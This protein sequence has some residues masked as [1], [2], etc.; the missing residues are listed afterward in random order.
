MK[1]MITSALGPKLAGFAIIV[2]L[3]L[4]VASAGGMVSQ[5]Y[6]Q[7]HAQD[8]RCAGSVAF[9]DQWPTVLRSQ[10][11]SDGQVV[12]TWYG[13][14]VVP[15]L[16]SGESGESVTV[17]NEAAE[18]RVGDPAAAPYNARD[19]TY[20]EGRNVWIYEPAGEPPDRPPE[21]LPQGVEQ[22][23]QWTY[24][25]NREYWYYE[26]PVADAGVGG[27]VAPATETAG[28]TW[29]TKE[30]YDEAALGDAHQSHTLRY[31]IFRKGR[32]RFRV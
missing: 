17:P 23:G 29:R 4:V 15:D 2:T 6:R 24:H 9:T 30:D 1:K 14:G 12:L 11:G 16:N 26:P 10:M 25:A 27:A 31:V 7:A 8:D 20:V 5:D 13:P 32:G 22:G 3:A 19:W 28:C 21:T 18:E